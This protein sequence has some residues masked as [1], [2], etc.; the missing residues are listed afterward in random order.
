MYLSDALLQ[1]HGGVSHN[2]LLSSD[3][4]ICLT[5]FISS[6]R[7]ELRAPRLPKV[8]SNRLNNPFIAQATQVLNTHN[9]LTDD[10]YCG[11]VMG[12]VIAHS[13]FPLV[14]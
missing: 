9:D 10:N 5:C 13:R 14:P 6:L 1:L 12:K 4:L 11:L 7:E 2:L 3:L 8:S